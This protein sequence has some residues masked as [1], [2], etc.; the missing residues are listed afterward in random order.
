MRKGLNT[1]LSDWITKWARGHLV[2][3]P[4]RPPKQKILGETANFRQRQRAKNCQ[5][6]HFMFSGLYYKTITIVI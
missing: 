3:V 5:P 2:N 4:F 1:F 6:E